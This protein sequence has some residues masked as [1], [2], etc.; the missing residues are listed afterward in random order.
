[1]LCRLN[2]ELFNFN[3][4]FLDGEGPIYEKYRRKGFVVYQ[5]NYWKKP[6]YITFWN[7]FW[8]LKK[9]RYKIIH[10]FG[11]RA[12]IIGRIIAKFTGCKII[13]SSQRS[14]D[15]WRRW[16]HILLDKITSRWVTLYIS[17][18]YAAAIRLNRV[19]KIPAKKIIVIHN[20]IDVKRFRS[21]K[22]GAV[23]SE[24]NIPRKIP[25]ISC[26]ANFRIAKG[27]ELLIE[28]IRKLRDKKVKFYLWLVGEGELKGKIKSKVKNLDLSDCVTF[29]GQRT[30]IPQILADSD[31]FALA[32]LWEGMPG[33]IMEAMASKLPVVATA[34]GG[35]P[36]L[37]IDGKTGFL[38]PPK[39]P[40]AMATAIIKL[41]NDERLRK[42]MGRAG[43]WRII[44]H[45]RLDDKVKQ[46]EQIYLKLLN[47]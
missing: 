14:I 21:V 29:L 17:N 16:W 26:V 2:R 45:F 34:V 13:I 36:E 38:V 10:I 3:I 5:L 1:M 22:K 15:T 40:E 19:E 20:G 12:N 11:L 41:I 31:I 35:I 8:L 30:D 32:S 46:Q 4:C 43:Y 33:A 47:L 23:R 25:V 6:L 42:K 7:L 44:K 28:A 24:L 27:H 9:N 37:V 39:D 18:S